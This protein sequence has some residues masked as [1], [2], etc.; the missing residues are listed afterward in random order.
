MAEVSIT[1]PIQGDVFT[2]G[3][4]VLPAYTAS[5]RASKSEPEKIVFQN[6]HASG[7]VTVGGSDAGDEVNGVVL[8]AQYESVTLHLTDP[9]VKVYLYSDT[10]ATPVGVTRVG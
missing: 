4:S 7:V 5:D 3:T 9:G 8:A 1:Q 10:A 6:L 2:A